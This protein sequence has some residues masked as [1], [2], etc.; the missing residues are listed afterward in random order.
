MGGGAGPAPAVAQ[1]S[2]VWSYGESK[3]S[4]D[5]PYW[6]YGESGHYIELPVVA[7]MI[8]MSSIANKLIGDCLI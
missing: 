5:D 3:H 8:P 4:L 7:A 2:P 6:S 1:N